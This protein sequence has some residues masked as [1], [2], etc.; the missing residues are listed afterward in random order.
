MDVKATL[1]YVTESHATKTPMVPAISSYTRTDRYHYLLELNE[2]GEILGGEWILGTNEHPEWGVS[3]QP[4][5]LWFSTGPA[6]DYG[7]PLD[8]ANIRKLLEL[9]RAPIVPVSDETTPPAAHKVE[10]VVAVG[11]TIPDNSASGLSE[12]LKVE[13]TEKA[14]TFAVQVDV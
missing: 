3:K 2:A 14:I 12:S 4:D 13:R 6:T 5:F 8:I 7:V 11:A 10:Q 9:S 1:Y